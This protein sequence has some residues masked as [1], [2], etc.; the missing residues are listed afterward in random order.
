[1]MKMTMIRDITPDD[2]AR[3]LEMAQ[4]F[5]SSSA[6]DHAIE[7]RLLEATFDQALEKS[8]YVRVLMLEDDG[9][10]VGFGILAL[11]H[12]TEVGGLTVLLEDLYIDGSC[13]GKGLGSKF[14]RFVEEEYPSAK[15]FRLE[16][17]TANKGA[18]ELYRRLGY[19]TLSYVQMVKDV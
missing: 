7:S 4:G 2:R 18:I 15:R 6:V 13:R 17:A 9:R 10:I 8:P 14:M 19:K 12:A 5:Y 1:M 11:T 3:F 16:V